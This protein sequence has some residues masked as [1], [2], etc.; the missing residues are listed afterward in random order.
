MTDFDCLVFS[1]VDLLPENDRN[2]YGCPTS[3]RHMSVAVD[4]LNYRL[5]Y[6]AIF[7][8]V[9]A[10]LREHFENV[11]GMSNLFWGWGGED[12]DLY[13]R[14]VKKGYKLTRPSI[15]VGRYTMIKVKHHRSHGANPNRMNLLRDSQSR[16]VKDGLN[17]LKYRLEKIVEEP[18]VTFVKVDMSPKDYCKE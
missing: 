6:S 3:P 16:M 18:L 7:G 13:K 14:I 2:Y 5:P 12:D 4:T 1:D 17:G 15:K 11:N 9:G 8:G 10:F